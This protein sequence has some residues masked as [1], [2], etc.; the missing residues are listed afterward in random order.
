MIKRNTVQVSMVYKMVQH[1]KCHPT[2]NDI[3]TEIQKESP[4]ISRGTVYRNLDRLAKMGEIKKV[5]VPGGPEHFDFR[6][7]E[8]YHIKCN[9]CNRIYDVDMNCLSDLTDMIDDKQGFQ[10]QGYDVFF[11]GICPECNKKKEVI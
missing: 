2:A 3:Y 1:L 8:H 10:F 9:I 6:C 4:S 5:E 7:D 11:N